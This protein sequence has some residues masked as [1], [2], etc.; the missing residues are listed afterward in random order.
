MQST[1][2]ASRLIVNADDF[3]R[4]ASINQ[5]VQRAHREGILT[6]TSLM[7]N[8]P[9]FEEALVM[10]RANPQ[11]A[12]GL[13]L[14]LILGHAS[15]PPGEIPGLADAHGCFGNNPVSLG[16]R[17]FFQPALR[18][19]LQREIAAQIGKFQAT[20]LRMS[21][22]DGHMHLHM[23]PVVFS[24]LLANA[25]KWGLT[26]LRLTCEPLRPNLRAATGRVFIRTLHAAIFRCLAAWQRRGLAR[27][28]IRH[29]SAVF[30][31]LQDGRMNEDYVLRLLPELPPGDS[32]LY[33]HPSL[34]DF[35]HE[36][37]ALVSPRVKATAAQ[38]GIRL[39]RYQDL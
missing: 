15:L 7:V 34:D 27:L 2:V 1:P 11:L 3:G 37:D 18:D 6:S 5:A 38:L 35:K 32:E 36:F 39:I 12:V 30:G 4:S 19:Q 21:H 13:H 29:T 10:A 31:Q 9:G 17:Y 16:F 33:M 23:Q 8:E 14:T 24:I 25:R 26:H 28:G 22:L 20:G